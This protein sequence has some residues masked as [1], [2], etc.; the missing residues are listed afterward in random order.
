[1][2]ITEIKTIKVDSN[3]VDNPVFVSWLNVYGGREHWLFKGIQTI[4]L[5]TSEGGEFEPFILDLENSRGQISTI[6][7]DAVPQL[8][9]SAYVDIEDVQ[10]LKTILYSPCVEMLM[11]PDKWS[12]TVAPIWQII[13]PKTG[14]FKICNTNELKTEIEI[15]FDLPYIFTQKQ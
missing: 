12:S 15:T 8:I 1:M 6:E 2:R 9:V 14:S 11:N 5:Q 10:G 3:C 7:I 13:R 4:G